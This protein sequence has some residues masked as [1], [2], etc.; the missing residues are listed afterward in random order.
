MYAYNYESCNIVGEIVS[1]MTSRICSYDG[2]K[3]NVCTLLVVNYAE[4][5]LR[6]KR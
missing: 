4:K 2:D 1:S 3:G 6:W 5:R